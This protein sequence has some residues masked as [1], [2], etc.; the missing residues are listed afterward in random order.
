MGG[1]RAASLPHGGGEVESVLQT[2]ATHLEF[3]GHGWDDD[4]SSTRK[5]LNQNQIFLHNERK[6]MI[7]PQC[8]KASRRPADM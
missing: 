2:R 4:P 1:L 5:P 7:R 6:C 3:S 8:L